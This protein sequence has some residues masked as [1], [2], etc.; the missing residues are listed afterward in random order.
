MSPISRNWR[1]RS[2]QRASL[3]APQLCVAC[4]CAGCSS[5]AICILGTYEATLVPRRQLHVCEGT[6]RSH[7][8]ITPERH[9]H[10]C[11]CLLLHIGQYVAVEVES[12]P[13]LGVAQ[14][15]AHDLGIDASA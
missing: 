11:C 2:L 9:L 13:D 4:S 1:L 6:R 15:L 12:D 3:S 5:K 14:H 8:R 7:S 10:L